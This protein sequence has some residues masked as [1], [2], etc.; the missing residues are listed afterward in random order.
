MSG[1]DW[2]GSDVLGMGVLLA[3][4]CGVYEIATRLSDSTAY[5][6]GEAVAIG[7]VFLT[8]WVYLDVGMLVDISTSNTNCSTPGWSV[9]C[10]SP[11]GVPTTVA[12][13]RFGLVAAASPAA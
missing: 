7:D 13:M 8:I 9:G 6:A 12:L 10:G 2:S 11:R 4:V 3:I 1:V 5:R